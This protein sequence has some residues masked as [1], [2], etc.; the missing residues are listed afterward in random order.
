MA[1][2]RLLLR[3]GGVVHQFTS[4]EIPDEDIASLGLAKAISPA[5]DTLVGK[6][7][8][9]VTEYEKNKEEQ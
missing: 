2:V 8:T 6:L 7:I 9:E 5:I 3:Y 1:Q 4:D